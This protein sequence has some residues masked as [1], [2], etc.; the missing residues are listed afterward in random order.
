[1]RFTAI[2]LLACLGLVAATL[3]LSPTR[4][5]GA[6]FTVREP[7]AAPCTDSVGPS[8]PPPSAASLVSGLP[9]HHAQLYGHSGR[10]VL[11]PGSTATATIAFHNSGSLGWY[12]EGAPLLLGT[13]G[14][15]PGQDRSSILGGD[16]SSGS[17][18]TGWPRADRAAIQPV[19]YIGPGQVA[20]FRFAVK[21]PATPGTYRLWLRPVVEGRQWLGEAVE[22]SVTV[23]TGDEPPPPQAAPPARTYLP[24]YSGGVRSIRVNVLLYHYVDAVPDRSDALRVDLTTSPA[25]LEEQLLYLKA[26]GYTP[27]TTNDIWWTLDQGAALPPKPVNLSFDDGLISQYDNAYRLLRKHGITATF[28]VTANLVGREGY[29]TQAMLR[30]MAAGGMDIQSHAVDHVSLA[31]ATPEAQRYQACSARRILSE[32]I[33]KDVRHFA[34]PA[35]GYDESAF[36]ALASCGY[37]SAYWTAGGSLQRSDR[38]LLLSRERVRGLARGAAALLV[39]LSR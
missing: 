38:T 19:P 3:A 26:H 16:G 37:L 4:A 34:Y 13:W 9:G 25:D 8:S 14:P 29:V 2:R 23:K 15:E 39:P 17:P 33:G 35:G 31:G 32:W 36:D 22:W 27:V 24:A 21:A 10:P 5:S 6:A 12:A 1:M 30:E 11:C 18:A 28:Y 20:W 7:Q